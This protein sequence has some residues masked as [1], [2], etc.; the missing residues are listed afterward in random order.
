MKQINHLTELQFQFDATIKT[1]A[2]KQTNKQRERPTFCE[3]LDDSRFAVTSIR[4]ELAALSK[5][6][7]AIQLYRNRKFIIQMELHNASFMSVLGKK[8]EYVRE[9]KLNYRL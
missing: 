7:E 8:V 2:N 9:W 6:M 5:I 1:K 4:R 3:L